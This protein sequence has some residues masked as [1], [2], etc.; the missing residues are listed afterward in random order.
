MADN[1]QREKEI[2]GEAL[3][4]GSLEEQRAFVKGACGGDEALQRA[5]E[6]LLESYSKAGGFIPTRLTAPPGDPPGS[7]FSE[8]PGT[9]IGRYKLL[10]KIGEGGMGVVYMAEQEEPVRRRVA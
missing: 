6:A 5:I 7:T 2:F 3:E 10:Q 8:G 4:L 1:S 9:L